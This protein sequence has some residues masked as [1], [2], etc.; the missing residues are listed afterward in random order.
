MMDEQAPEQEPDEAGG[1]A[2]VT[3]AV[4]RAVCRMMINYRLAP[5]CE[6]SLP[7]GR[8]ADVIGLSEKG[9]LT[10]VEVKSGPADFRSDSKWPEYFDYCDRFFFAFSTEF[11]KELIPEEDRCGVILSDGWEAAIVREAPENRLS[12]ARRKAVTIRLARASILRPTASEIV[13]NSD[14]GSG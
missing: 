10:I 12:A 5:F 4:T 14:E 2:E 11:P 3:R 8:R 1:A 9:E 6:F 13:E 7:N